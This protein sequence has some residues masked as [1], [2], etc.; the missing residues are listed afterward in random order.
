MVRDLVAKSLRQTNSIIQ[1]G[2]VILFSHRIM[3]S[4]VDVSLKVNASTGCT[5]RAK[6]I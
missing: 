3:K 1:F 5:I 6:A 2:I 4:Y